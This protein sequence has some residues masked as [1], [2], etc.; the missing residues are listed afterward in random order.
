[1]NKL[2]KICSLDSAEFF[3]HGSMGCR[4]RQVAGGLLLASLT[5]ACW[6]DPRIDATN[7]S[8]V[9]SADGAPEVGRAAGRESPKRLRDKLERAGSL[10]AEA[11]LSSNSATRHSFALD[12]V[13][14]LEEI[15]P[16]FERG[17]EDYW[18]AKWMYVH[19]RAYL[20]VDARP[21]DIVSTLQEMVAEDRS[22]F[23]GFA[24]VDVATTLTRSGRR[25]EA[26]A[27]AER[28]LPLVC[29]NARDLEYLQLRARR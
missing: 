8:V 25:V 2:R 14:I 13:E 24:I 17:G 27:I 26:E 10:N 15:M 4:A 18:H 20:T 22:R 5:V 12:A 29:D 11:F 6:G 19:A 7:S 28:I 23:Q 21:K 9:R 16:Q 3:S 1:M